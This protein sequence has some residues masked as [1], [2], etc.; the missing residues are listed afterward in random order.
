ML[1]LTKRK[2]FDAIKEGK[3]TVDIRKAAG[4]YKNAKIGSEILF[5]CGRQ[6]FTRKIKEIYRG[7]L[8]EILEEV[9]F[10]EIIPW[11]KSREEFIENLREI[12]PK[13]EEFVAF[14]IG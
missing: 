3:K 14:R 10:R 7:T 8:E 11:A 12:Y 5:M 2:Y 9:D 6:K 1:L 13:Q 4:L